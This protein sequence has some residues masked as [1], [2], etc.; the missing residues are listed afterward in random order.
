MELPFTPLEAIALGLEYVRPVLTALIVVISIDVILLLLAILGV[1]GGFRN[2][3]SALKNALGVGGVVGVITLLLAVPATGASFADLSGWIDYAT[4][5]G[6]AAGFG[7][8]AAAVTYP[9]LQLIVASNSYERVGGT[10]GR[11]RR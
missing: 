1:A 10:I 6:A 8:A 7:L 11:Y 5:F 9:P 3:G 2:A 4:L